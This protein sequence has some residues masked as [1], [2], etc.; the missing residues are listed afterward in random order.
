MDLSGIFGLWVDGFIAG[1]LLG[2]I[3]FLF[4]LLIN[5]GFGLLKK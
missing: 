5:Y 3:P 2:G 1:A 4:G